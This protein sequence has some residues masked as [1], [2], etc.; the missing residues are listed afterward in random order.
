MKI[1]WNKILCLCMAVISCLLAATGCSK[2]NYL[3]VSTLFADDEGVTY[4]EDSVSIDDKR[5]VKLFKDCE[6]E[7]GEGFVVSYTVEGNNPEYKYAN[8][9]G[10]YIEYED[11]VEEEIEGN[12]SKLWHNLIIF[13]DPW[14][15]MHANACVWII[16]NGP[17]AQKGDGAF[18]RTEMPFAIASNPVKVTIVYYDEAYYIELDNSYTV[19][20]TADMIPANEE[21][22]NVEKF[23][24][25][26]NRKIG[27][28]SAETGATFSKVSY[29]IGNEAALEAIKEMKIDE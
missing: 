29:S 11:D 27:F 25:A 3:D 5:T 26:G 17:Y 28:R 14:G 16:E 10:L 4:T 21:K 2:K 23:F 6:V 7:E 9:G 15:Q 8:T 19:K 18:Y 24:A 1:K 12:G 13:H 20:L 22:I